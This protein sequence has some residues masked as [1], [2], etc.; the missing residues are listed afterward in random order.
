MKVSKVIGEVEV[1]MVGNGWVFVCL[2]GIELLVRVMV[3]VVMKEEIDE[4][5]ECILVVVCLEMVFND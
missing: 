4:Y 2:L 3:E 1:E 5:C